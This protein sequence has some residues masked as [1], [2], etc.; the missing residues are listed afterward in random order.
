MNSALTQNFTISTIT[1]CCPTP[2]SLIESSDRGAS[3]PKLDVLLSGKFLLQRG[4]GTE[5]D[6]FEEL[7]P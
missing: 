5:I 6:R 2:P 3:G 4:V 1:C 7:N